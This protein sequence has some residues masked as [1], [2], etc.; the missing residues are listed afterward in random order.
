MQ[1]RKLAEELAPLNEADDDGEDERPLITP[2]ELQEVYGKLSAFCDDFDYDCVV[3]E[4][5]VL[6]GFRI[7]EEE[8]ARVEA[9]INAVDDLDYELI[10]EIISGEAAE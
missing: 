5:E 10:P 9:I 4:V 1:Y 2:E 6:K 3:D 8:A 7:P